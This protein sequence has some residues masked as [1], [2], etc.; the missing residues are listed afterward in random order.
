MALPQRFRKE[1]AFRQLA[2]N[3]FSLKYAHPKAF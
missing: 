2:K 3:E 1:L